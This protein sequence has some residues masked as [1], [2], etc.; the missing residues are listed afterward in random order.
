MRVDWENGEFMEY[1]NFKF[2]PWDYAVFGI[3][4]FFS[5]TIGIWIWW[6]GR[7]HFGPS[8]SSSFSSN[9]KC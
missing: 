7:V 5:V 1:K 3:L 6:T 8:Q 9:F 2:G 4:L